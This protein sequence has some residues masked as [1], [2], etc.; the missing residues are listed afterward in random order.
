[1]LF[2]KSKLTNTYYDDD[3]NYPFD[4]SLQ[5]EKINSNLEKC[6][7]IARHKSPESI[8]FDVSELDSYMT[9][10]VFRHGCFPWHL[11]DDAYLDISKMIKRT[12]YS[13]GAKNCGTDESIE[14]RD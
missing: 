9:N 7:E 5:I 12:L 14:D 6:Y 3:G 13:L 1:M 11:N 4:N 2:I 8:F 10:R